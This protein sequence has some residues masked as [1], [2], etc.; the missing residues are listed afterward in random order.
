MSVLASKICTE[1][2]QK[3]SGRWNS[4][5]QCCRPMKAP[6]AHPSPVKPSPNST[7]RSALQS[8]KRYTSTVSRLP[9]NT[10]RFR[11]VQP[12]KHRCP[13]LCSPSGNMISVRAVQFRKQYG[14]R[15][16]APAMVTLVSFLS[17]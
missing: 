12:M 16:A 10:T 4:V 5:R 15:L 3:L 2:L 14:P 11:A 6:A 7:V 8:M 9:G 1:A 13:M 17:P